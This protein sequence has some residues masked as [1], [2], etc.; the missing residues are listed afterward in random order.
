MERRLNKKIED[1]LISFK[2]DIAKKLQQMVNGL[3]V[4]D[5]STRDELMKSIDNTKLQCNSMAGFVYTMKSCGLEKTT[6]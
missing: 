3:E 1:Y 5:A 2:N 4:H 6:L